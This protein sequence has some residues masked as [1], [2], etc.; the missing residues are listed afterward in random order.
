MLASRLLALLP[1][2]ARDRRYIEPFL[3]AASLFFAL[4]PRRAVLSDLNEHLIKCY[5][6]IQND[7][8]RVAAQLRQLAAA[9]SKDH[10]YAIRN[11]YNRAGSSVSQAARFIYLNQTCFNGVFRVNRDGA[12]NVPFGDK[13]NP[14]F[15]TSAELARLSAVLKNAR[16]NACDY[17]TTLKT[18]RK[19]DLVYLDPPYPPL[20]GTSYF[21][22]Y[23]PERFSL[24]EQERIAGVFESLTR[25]GCLVMMTNAD[26]PLVRRLYRGNAMK[27]IRVPRYVT[28][29]NV[30]H[31]VGELVIMNYQPPTK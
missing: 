23:T 1:K 11:T 19:G 2:D 15:P 17:E 14:L 21:T 28:C 9:N 5:R 3:G 8:E 4:R 26:T 29:K 16:L 31:S 18:V 7:H 24:V 27:S 12:F 10:Y 20:N 13:A 6:F 22:H 30:R 25:R